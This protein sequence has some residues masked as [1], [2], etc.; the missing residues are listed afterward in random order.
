MVVRYQCWYQYQRQDEAELMESLT[1]AE[2]EP[3]PPCLSPGPLLLPLAALRCLLLLVLLVLLV[4]LLL[5]C[6][7]LQCCTPHTL[8]AV[9]GTPCP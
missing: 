8:S 6:C 5:A 2:M 7:T 9:W 1:E 4:L 3:L